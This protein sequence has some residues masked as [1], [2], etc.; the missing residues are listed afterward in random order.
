MKTTT[1]YVTH[2]QTDAMTMA[3]K[4]VVLN[5]GRIVQ[6]GHPLELYRNPGNLFV[7][8]FIGF[9]QIHHDGTGTAG[10]WRAYD[11]HQTRASR[12]QPNWRRLE[13]TD[14]TG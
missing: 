1:I 14:R 12:C 6:V 4:V 9:P 5:A 10:L 8:T 13:G 3:D 11:R 7:A 2:D